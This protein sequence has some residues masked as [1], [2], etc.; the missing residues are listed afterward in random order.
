MLEGNNNFLFVALLP[1]KKN[2]GR[3]AHLYSEVDIMLEYD[4]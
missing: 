3:Q 4:H 2:E 1:T